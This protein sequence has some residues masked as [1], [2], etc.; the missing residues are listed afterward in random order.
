M[1]K[2]DYVREFV[3]IGKLIEKAESPEDLQKY[4]EALRNLMH[5]YANHLQLASTF[6][7]AMDIFD[8]DGEFRPET[9]DRNV[10]D[11]NQAEL[12]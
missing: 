7:H 1:T 2:N 5:T 6:V 12:N 10:Y 9:G 3:K 11:N 8:P 4:S